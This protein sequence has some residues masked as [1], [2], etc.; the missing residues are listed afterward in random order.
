MSVNPE[1]KIMNHRKDTMPLLNRRSVTAKEWRPFWELKNLFTPSTSSGVATA[2]RALFLACMILLSLTALMFMQVANTSVVELV[3]F[4]ILFMWVSMGLI[5]AIMGAWVMWRGD[6]HGL[7]AKSVGSAPITSKTAVIMPICN[8]DV[9]TVFSGLRATM[10]SCGTELF[11]FYVLSDT[12]NTQVKAHELLAYQELK[13]AGFNIHYRHRIHRTKKKSGN[14]E[15]FCRRWGANYDYMIVLDADSIMTGD[16]MEKMV[17]LMDKNPDAGI[18]QSLPKTVGHDTIHAR[19][20]QFSARMIGKIFAAG[21]QFWQLGES[22]Y[23]GHNAIIRVAPF[24]EHCA[25]APLRGEGNLSGTI[26]S[27]DF[28]EAALIRRAGYKVWIVQDLE[29]SYEQQPPNM[30]AELQ[31]DRRWCQGNL[32]NFKLITQPGLHAVHR[33]MLATGAMSYLSAPIWLMF[34]IISSF[35]AKHS[36]MVGLWI[37]TASILMLP[38][39]LALFVAIMTK[40]AKL[41]GGNW[42]IVKSTFF[43]ALV[44]LIQAPIKMTAHSLFVFSAL[45]GYKLEWKSPPRHADNV[46]FAEAFSFFSPF[47]LVSLAAMVL[48]AALSPMTLIWFAPICVPIILAVPFV[49]ITSRSNVGQIIKENKYLLVPEETRIPQVILNSNSFA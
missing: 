47:A 4:F 28:V 30:L 43:E 5:T 25:L 46:S 27:H 21:M 26:L 40:E 19:V 45:T 2:R 18:I 6:P 1:G 33:A 41:Y 32:Q 9:K 24:M 12:S 42:A 36:S 44:S 10:L 14:V 13:D 7:S 31:R 8:E 49:M 48:H 35:N 20:Q 22:H 15:D 34:I 17:L 39:F 3:L 38:R 11:D 23:W 29:G 16:C 37:L